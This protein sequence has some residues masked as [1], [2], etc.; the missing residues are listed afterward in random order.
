MTYMVDPSFSQYKGWIIMKEAK[1]RWIAYSLSICNISRVYN[2]ISSRGSYQCSCPEPSCFNIERINR[3]KARDL[4][5]FIQT[6]LSFKM[7]R[8]FV[9]IAA[10]AVMTA[11]AFPCPPSQEPTSRAISSKTSF[12][13][14]PTNI[15]CFAARVSD[16]CHER[17]WVTSGRLLGAARGEYISIIYIILGEPSKSSGPSPF[18]VSVFLSF[19]EGGRWSSPKKKTQYTSLIWKCWGIARS[20]NP[21]VLNRMI[22]GCVEQTQISKATARELLY[23]TK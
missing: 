2:Y 9:I 4:Y 10:A 5:I 8:L 1:K 11:T 7:V 14:T 16:F 3:I 17:V 13:P 23:L 6:W 19:L 12:C 15:L 22:N 21:W 18:S 20:I